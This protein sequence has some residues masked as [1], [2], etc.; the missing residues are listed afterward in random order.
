[1]SAILIKFLKNC[2]VLLVDTLLLGVWGWRIFCYVE[3]WTSAALIYVSYSCN[4]LRTKSPHVGVDY[5]Y[6][7]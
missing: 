1:M 7:W 6:V 3:T 2:I 5:S 4:P